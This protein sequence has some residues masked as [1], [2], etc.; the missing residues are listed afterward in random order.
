M[1]DELTLV[2]GA[3]GKTGR[4]LVDQ[5]QHAGLPYR[6][7]SRH[8]EPAFDWED[9][10]T[11]DD[12][13]RDVT[14]A[15]LIAPGTVDDPYSLVIDFAAQAQRTGVRRFVF[16]SMSSI[17]AGGPAHGQVHQWLK[18]NCH[19]WAVLCPTAFM[20][21]FSEGP[22][23]ASIRDEDRIYSN[24]GS[25][26]VPFIHA[27]DIAAAALA[28]LT[29]PTPLNTDFVLTS[30]EPLSYDGVAEIISDACGRHI[31]HTH[32]SSETMIQHY[33]SRGIPET[34]ARFLAFGYEWI[35]GGG[36][37]NTTD[38]VR[39]LTGRPPIT[40]RAFAEANAHVWSPLR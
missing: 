15:Y 36:E 7:G 31:T 2:T 5:L 39:D 16:L 3:T 32:V 30:E 21:N 20:Q 38:A 13:L 33:I 27:D 18:D 6:A 4:S 11:W 29:S 17:P 14:C 19:D 28:A 23:Q 25:G 22:Y 12:A 9:R 8:G 35:A 34:N 37:D 40:F 1:S 24:T 26:R 10:S